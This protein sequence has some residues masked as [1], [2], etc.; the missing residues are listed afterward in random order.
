MNPL[1]RR[2]RTQGKE[3]KVRAGQPERRRNAL[4]RKAWWKRELIQ[5]GTVRD[6]EDQGAVAVE[7]PQSGQIV[8]IDHNLESAHHP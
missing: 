4:A 5:V 6:Q 3:V 1:R 7:F 8:V 2:E